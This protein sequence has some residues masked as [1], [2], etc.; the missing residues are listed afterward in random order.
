MITKRQR[1][2][3][4]AVYVNPLG[5][6]R[7]GQPVYTND[8][9]IRYQ[10]R[11]YSGY[12]DIFRDLGFLVAW[13][14]FKEQILS[15]EIRFTPIDTEDNNQVEMCEVL[16]DH[17]S[18]QIGWL[19][20][21]LS[22]EI[23]GWTVGSLTWKEN[24]GFKL[25]YFNAESQDDFHWV[26]QPKNAGKTKLPVDITRRFNLDTRYGGGL[27]GW[28]Q[29]F[30]TCCT[31]FLPDVYLPYGRGL[32]EVLY[33]WVRHLKRGGLKAWIDHLETHG[34]PTLKIRQDS[35]G[36]YNLSSGVTESVIDTVSQIL[37]NR[38]ILD[39]SGLPG[40][41]A[42]YLNNPGLVDPQKLTD[43]ID[44]L[45]RMLLLGS[46][47]TTKAGAY[48]T[49]ALGE[50][51]QQ[52]SEQIQ[53]N[54][55]ENITRHLLPTIRLVVDE[56]WGK[57][58]PTPEVE[59]LKPSETDP[60]EEVE[61]WE[62]LHRI[63]YRPT[64]EKVVET[65]GPGYEALGG[66][67]DSLPNSQ[68]PSNFGG[69]NL[70]GVEGPADYGQPGIDRLIAQVQEV[71]RG[72]AQDNPGL[73]DRELFQKAQDGLIAAFPDMPVDELGERL[74][75]L[76]V[77]GNVAGRAHVLDEVLDEGLDEA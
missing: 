73:S 54:A 39:L 71:L 67:S 48:G 8:N 43:Y 46:N 3:P 60:T 45:C 75:Y 18:R 17:F 70:R 32:G 26:Y 76:M 11:L 16:T 38:G 62:K 21:F 36:E 40:V 24:D 74:Q 1:L 25:P 29:H 59:L 14:Q 51:H 31:F 6:W 34:L 61:R 33:W 19:D 49:Q 66:L 20:A 22:T 41:D 7:E 47:L 65:L 10:L 30:S 58:M 64:Q 68:E 37:E 42:E 52:V 2:K 77:W 4:D 72:V 63:G 69:Y 15:R 44:E 55:A 35:Q 56:N 12:Q 50:I 57:D 28:H 5:A 27:R 23:Y 53:G 9:T 13:R